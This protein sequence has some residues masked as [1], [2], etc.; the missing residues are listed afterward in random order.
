MNWE[1]ELKKSAALRDTLKV[2]FADTFRLIDL[3][4]YLFICLF[5]KIIE[6]DFVL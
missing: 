2:L 4:I 5:I 1:D 3:F 6:T